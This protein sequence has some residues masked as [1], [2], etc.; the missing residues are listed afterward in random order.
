TAIPLGPAVPRRRLRWPLRL[1]LLI[2]VVGSAAAGW[3]LS[4]GPGSM[5]VVPPVAVRPL[6]DAEAALRQAALTSQSSKAFSETVAKGQVISGDPSAGARVSK[7]S[8]VNL[9]V[10]KGPE[11]YAVPDLVGEA[12]KSV[13]DQLTPL[14]LKV[15][16]QAEVW[17]ETVDKGVVIKQEPTEGTSVR[18]STPIDLVV[19]KGREP[20]PVPDVTGETLDEATA[21]I[22]D[23]ELTVKRLPDANSDTVPADRV[24][25]QQPAEG[26][27]CRGDEG[28]ITV[29]KGPVLVTVPRVL[30]KP[31]AEA[32][33]TLEK[34]GFT[35]KV[36]RP[37]GTF[38]ELVRDQSVAPDTPAPEGSTIVLTVV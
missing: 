6:A 24:I 18:R 1:L 7:R 8:V 2:L 20:M 19:S 28:A 23:A 14:T 17:S 13:A 30:G 3:W 27:L 38:F 29:S 12:A 36:R 35:V 10:S 33:K 37:L 9:L 25:S 5:T 21:Q 15:G 34:L 11:R 32:Q 26:T 4:V 22:T 31:V 16:H